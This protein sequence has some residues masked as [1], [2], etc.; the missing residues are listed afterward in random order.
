M[1]NIID[2]ESI[3]LFDNYRDTFRISGSNEKEVESSIKLNLKGLNDY[4]QNAKV[5]DDEKEDIKVTQQNSVDSKAKPKQTTPVK[6]WNE[7]KQEKDVL[8]NR[9]C[10][11]S[12][13]LSLIL[14]DETLLMLFFTL[15]SFCSLITLHEV[16]PIQRAMLV[17]FLR[18]YN[19]T[20]GKGSVMAIVAG[21]KD[22]YL[23]KEADVSIAIQKNFKVSD[24]QAAA[25]IVMSDFY[26]LTYLLFKHGTQ[27][28]RRIFLL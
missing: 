25:D 5:E 19:N 11:G 12:Q 2:Y 7:T 13:Q 9:L 15:T 18:Q 26:G 27:L 22:R 28:Q 14:T 16:D 6:P 21:N 20:G 17:K 10:V 1:R 3:D 4:F 23:I 24:L 8:K